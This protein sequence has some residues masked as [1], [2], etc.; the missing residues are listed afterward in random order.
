M[1]GQQKALW[2]KEEKGEFAVGPRSIDK[3]GS[4]ELLVK[5]EATALNP[6]STIVRA[7]AHFVLTAIQVDWKIQTYAFS[8]GVRRHRMVYVP[9]AW[10]LTGAS[11]RYPAILGSDSAGVV[12]ELGEGVTGWKKGDRV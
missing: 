4:G 7:R 9:W 8:I 12:E 2:L 6:V 1:C 5:I 10:K 3:P 11:Q